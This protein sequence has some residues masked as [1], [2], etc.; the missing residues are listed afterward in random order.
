MTLVGLAVGRGKP[1]NPTKEGEDPGISPGPG[2]QGHATKTG[3]TLDIALVSS[4]FLLTSFVNE[5]TQ[6]K[7][8]YY[9]PGNIQNR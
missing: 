7:I 9:N 5:H 3:F 1:A 8:K 6:A 2:P 4:L